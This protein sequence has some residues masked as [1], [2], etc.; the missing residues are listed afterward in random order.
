M[1]R[2][3]QLVPRREPEDRRY[4]RFDVPIEF[5]LR[6]LMWEALQSGLCIPMHK[7]STDTFPDGVACEGVFYSPERDCFS[8]ILYHPS[9]SSVPVGNSIP[10]VEEEV[11]IE[12]LTLG[13]DPTKSINS[14]GK[15]NSWRDLPSLLGG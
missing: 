7:F 6:F 5:P 8:Y 14:L 13:D 3:P 9:W 2:Y 10:P 4:R 1:S 12:V 15:V 11:H